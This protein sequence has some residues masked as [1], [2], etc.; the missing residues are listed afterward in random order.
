[1]KAVQYKK[2]TRTRNNRNVSKGKANG[3]KVRTKKSRLY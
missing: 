3:R 1:M 2:V